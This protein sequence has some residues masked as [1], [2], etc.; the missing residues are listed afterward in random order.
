MAG[1]GQ[2]SPY[3]VLLRSRAVRTP[4]RY[5][6]S[7]TTNS[8][9]THLP[10]P[11]ASTPQTSASRSTSSRPA[12]GDARLARL[13]AARQGAGGVLDLDAQPAVAAGEDPQGDDR[14]ALGVHE[15]VGDQ[16]VGDQFD[17]VGAVPGAPGADRGPDHV[18][19][20][21][22]GLGVA[23][24]HVLLEP[25]AG[26]RASGPRRRSRSSGHVVVAAAFLGHLD[27]PVGEVAVRRPGPCAMSAARSRM[28]SS[29]SA[30]GCSTRPSVHSS[31]VSPG[32][33][34]TVLTGYSRL[35]ELGGQAERQAALDAAAARQLP[36][37]CADQRVDVA[38]P[39]HLHH[40]GGQVGLGVQAGGEAV[41]V[42]LVE[43]DGGAGH[44][45]G[46][47]VP[48][49]GVGAQHDA[50]LA[51]DGGGV[52]VVALDVADDGADPAAGQ[53]DHVVPVAADVPAES[54]AER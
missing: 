25:A 23:G 16:L 13:A 36:S 46:R 1:Y 11:R 17:L 18:P 27:E 47:G 4:P 35:P 50:Q 26:L 39:D 44:D 9:H 49:G 41:G 28:P 2:A 33:S 24:R 37:A 8:H 32:S 43:E 20:L 10:P 3:Y 6:C 48:L 30:P 52:R 42:E 53:R 38:G 22:E 12:A 7:G 45:G 51:H 31:S 14:G 54:A 34:S 5:R 21:A 29:R 40:P 19:G 15:G